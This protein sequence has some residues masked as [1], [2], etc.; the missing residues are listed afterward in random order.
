MVCELLLVL[1]PLG[2]RHDRIP[3]HTT[4]SVT[5]HDAHFHEDPRLLFRCHAPNLSH[6]ESVLKFVILRGFEPLLYSLRRSR[7]TLDDRTI[8][9]LQQSLGL[10]KARTYRLVFRK[11]DIIIGRVVRLALTGV[12]N[13]YLC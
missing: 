12:I 3:T 1:V 13:S 6:S 4:V 2:F 8:V 9:H 7:P 11:L 5:E 10:H